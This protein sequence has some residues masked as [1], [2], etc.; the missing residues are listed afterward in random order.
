MLNRTES[1][2]IYSPIDF[3]YKLQPLKTIV[4]DNGIPLRYISDQIEPV[5]Q[6]E[7][8]FPGGLWF[9]HK[10]G[11]A[12]ATAALLK[13]GTSTHTSFEINATFEQ[14]GAS[15]KAGAGNDWASITISCLTKHL[16]KLLPLLA[17]LLTDTIFPQSE[18]DIYIQNAKQRLSMMLKK[19][20]F[21]ANRKIDEYLFGIKHPYGKYLHKEDYDGVTQDALSYHLKTFYSSA[22]CQL[23]L[24]GTFGD[25]EL[26]LINKYLGAKAWNNENVVSIPSYEI[27]QE[28]TRKHRIVNDET[29]VQGSIRIANHF[30]EKHHPDFAPMIVLNTLF[31]GYFG[32]RLMSNI[33]EEKGY[34]YG[35]HSFMYNHKQL[36]AYMITTE[37]AKDVCEAAISEVYFEMDVLKKELVTEEELTLVKNYLLGNILGDLDGSFQ[38][39]QRWKNLLLND[40]TEERFYSN[41]NTYKTVTAEQLMELA[42]KYYQPENFYELVVY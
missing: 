29:S 5:L 7:M 21:I 30:P 19:G 15:I 32:S 1:P 11:I 26:H 37:A 36:S 31:G 40:F 25:N 9:E 4:L 24:A 34:T 41:I 27:I 16:D 23:F 33:R 13:S 35:I 20:D 28:T 6:L 8:I 38:I 22:N 39:I 3:E 12:Q 42:Q 18:I 10:I 14:Y 17:D 2:T